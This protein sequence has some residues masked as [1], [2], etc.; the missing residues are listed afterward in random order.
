MK[1]HPSTT[2]SPHAQSTRLQTAAPVV[3]HWHLE[4]LGEDPSN[5]LL[6]WQLQDT[7]QLH[8]LTSTCHVSTII[9]DDATRG[10]SATHEAWDWGT[11]DKIDSR[12]RTP[13]MHISTL[14]F[15]ASTWMG[16]NH[17]SLH[18]PITCSCQV[19]CVI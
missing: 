4:W 1:G 14:Q 5:S 3:G 12:A 11:M 18:K 9:K 7:F 13:N 10:L 19:S 2:G 6:L 16:S 8:T 17:S 15:N